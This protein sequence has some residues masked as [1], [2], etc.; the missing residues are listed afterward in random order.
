MRWPHF[1]PSEALDFSIALRGAS[2]FLVDECQR[3]W[4]PFVLCSGTRK[5][6]H[7]H[8]LAQTKPGSSHLGCC[9]VSFLT[10]SGAALP[11][12]SSILSNYCVY[13]RLE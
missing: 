8:E 4:C 11:C 3:A 5:H 7:A 13:C 10:E 12:N 2:A 6:F 1:I 9:R